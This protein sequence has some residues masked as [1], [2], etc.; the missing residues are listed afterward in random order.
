MRKIADLI[1][2]NTRHDMYYRIKDKV[3]IYTVLAPVYDME[4][5]MWE[6]IHIRLRINIRTRLKECIREINS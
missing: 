6:Q 4:F 5:K 3:D 1:Y 2:D